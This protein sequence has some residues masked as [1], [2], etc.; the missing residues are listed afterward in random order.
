MESTTAQRTT[1]PVAAFSSKW[2]E[3]WRN[4]LTSRRTPCTS[5][6]S[7]PKSRG[8][9]DRNT[10]EHPQVPAQDISLDLNYDIL[11]PI[12]VPLSADLG[13][14]E[15]IDWPTIKAVAKDFNLNCCRIPIPPQATTTA[16]DHFSLARAS[17]PAFSVDQ[18]ILFERHDEAWG[19]TQVADFEEHHYHQPSDEYNADWDFRGNAKIARFGFVLG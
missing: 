3:P 6:P 12:G 18:G 14:A 13:G 2:A 15:R 7:Q 11:L 9:S 4:R 8:C 16:P 19:R 10:C 5:P 17:V 1:A